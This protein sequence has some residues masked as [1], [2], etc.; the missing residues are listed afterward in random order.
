MGQSEPQQHAFAIR[1]TFEQKVDRLLTTSCAR[2][3]ERLI[4]AVCLEKGRESEKQEL[5][6]GVLGRNLDKPPVVSQCLFH[7]RTLGDDQLR[8]GVDTVIACG[9]RGDRE[10]TYLMGLQALMTVQEILP[11]DLEKMARGLYAET[12]SVRA[13]V[14]RDINRL[15][16]ER[17]A[18]MLEVN[19]TN[20]SL[21]KPFAAA[22]GMVVMKAKGAAEMFIAS[23][24]ER[25]P[26][27]RGPKHR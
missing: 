2:E 9:Y 19:E 20:T 17:L 16:I 7:L 18:R 12:A 24:E 5:Y 21:C 23:Y 8:R 26:A 11:A 27:M 15:D 6:H 10:A 4:N 22:F 14:E 25:I 13:G 3:I 1:M